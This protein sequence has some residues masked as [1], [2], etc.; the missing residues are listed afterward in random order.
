M[1]RLQPWDWHRYSTPSGVVDVRCLPLGGMKTVTSRM[2]WISWSNMLPGILG[3]VG[4]LINRFRYKG[5]WVVEYRMDS[6]D[7]RVLVEPHRAMSATRD[8]AVAALEQFGAWLSRGND[9]AGF[10][11]PQPA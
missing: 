10:D 3:I 8:P 5:T 6:V 2:N 9:P 4:Y 7:G 11:W 1:K